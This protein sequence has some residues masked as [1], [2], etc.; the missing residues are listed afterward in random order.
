MR[1]PTHGHCPSCGRDDVYKP[2]PICGR[3]YDRKKRGKAV[4]APSRFKENVGA[5]PA[6]R[7][8]AIGKNVAYR[9]ES[10]PPASPLNRRCLI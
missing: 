1:R 6:G 8:D 7:P 10:E 9:S 5:I 3:C 4:D 2:G